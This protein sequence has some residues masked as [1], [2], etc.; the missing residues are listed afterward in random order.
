MA[1]EGN[2]SARRGVSVRI[3]LADGTPDGLRIVE[4]SN[5]TGRAIMCSRAQYSSLRERDEFTRPGVYVL[6]GP[7]DTL[8]GGQAAYIGQADVAR[9]RLDSHVRTKE[10]WTHVIVFSSKDENLNKAHVQYLEARLI[11][12]ALKAKRV[13]VEN[14]NAP[15]L[16]NLSEADRADAEAFLD[17]ML[18][19]YPLLGVTAFE[20]VGSGAAVSAPR[21]HLKGKDC[22]ATGSDTPEGFIVFR[23]SVA[24]K[25]TV[26]SI[27]DFVLTLRS[28]L[29]EQKVLQPGLGGLSLVQ[30]YSFDSPSTAAA[31]FMGRNANGRIEWKDAEGRT[32]K[33]LQ[34]AALAGSGPQEQE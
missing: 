7:S 30:D 8:K 2:R 15:R 28:R 16:P 4:K 27:H 13:A 19:I 10:F 11:D 1:S 9:E 24:R 22:E 5:W 31:V 17:D 25:D 20:T 18:V 14:G 26:P 34:E 23:G 33:E 29:E 32:L 6:L 21:L 3:F 12:L